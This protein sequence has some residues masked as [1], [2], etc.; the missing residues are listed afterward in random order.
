MT[1]IPKIDISM[2]IKA[3][4]SD[5]LLRAK[6]FIRPIKTRT[7]E[8]YD[9]LPDKALGGTLELDDCMVMPGLWAY[10]MQVV[11]PLS[12]RTCNGEVRIRRHTLSGNPLMLKSTRTSQS[13][14]WK[15]PWYCQA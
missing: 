1:Q 13:I 15:K 8:D 4:L 3:F 10:M 14:T 7:L 5:I 6:M 2:S 12:S 11:A 9:V